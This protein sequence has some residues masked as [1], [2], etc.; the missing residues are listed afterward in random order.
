MALTKGQQTELEKATDTVHTMARM[1]IEDDV[2]P[3]A[4]CT[5]L[6]SE[7]TFIIKALPADSRRDGMCKLFSDTILKNLG[8]V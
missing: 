2:S 8:G 3:L 4:V 7:L 6:V 5:A 1:L